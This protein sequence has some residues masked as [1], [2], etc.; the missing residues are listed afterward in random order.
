MRS[1]ALAPLAAA[2]L[3]VFPAAGA[4][5]DAAPADPSTADAGTSSLQRVEVTGTRQRLDAARNAL[6]PDTGSSV[7]RLDKQDLKNLPLGESTPLNQVLLQT[8]GVVQD[9]YGQLHVRGDHA[10]VQYR[11]NGVII[12]ES[13]SGFGQALET[14]FADH[15][16]V[17]TGALPAQYGIRNAAVVDIQSKGDTPDRGGSVGLTLGSRGH[18]ETSLELSGTQGQLNYF[19]T[20]SLLRNDV[21]IENP[22]G[23][24]NALH[25]TT[26]QAK[27][28]GLLSY[29]LGDDSRVSLMFGTSNNRF[30]IPN[31]AGQSPR[32]TTDGHAPLDS[33]ALDARQ[34][35]SNRFVV[36]SYQGAIGSRVDYQLS[37][38]NRM[39]D[40]HYRPDAIGDL[41][42]NGI[43]ADILRRNDASGLQADFSY[44]LNPAHTLRAGLFA[45]QEKVD[46]A[47]GASVFPADADGNQSSGVP[48]FIQDD[49]RISG[50]LW[51]AYLQD[52]W[53]PV[54]PLTINYGLRYDQVHTVVVERQFS[55]RLGLVY[56]ASETLRLHAGYARYFTPPPTEKID[57]TSVAKFIGTTNALPSDANTAVRSERSDYF[58]AGLS[59]QASPQL[60][61]GID[62]YYRKVRHLQDEGQF[63]NAL[64]FSAFNFEQGR[65][66]GLDLSATY[67]GER[68]SGYVNLGL[69]HARAKGIESGQFNFGPD[70][71]D[72]IASHWVHLDHEQRFSGSAGLSYRFGGGLVASSDLLFGSGLRRGFANTGHLPAYTSVNAAVAKTFDLGQG[73]GKFDTRLAVVNLFDRVYQLRDGSGIGVGAPQFGLRRSVYVSVGKPF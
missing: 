66:H 64:I 61:L 45:Q 10:N 26:R 42:F 31:L 67:K 28:F 73:L 71:L 9:S 63:G 58:D 44:K 37:V 8:P 53:R 25:D 40:V 19:L 34:N 62:G 27:S 55:P 50:H 3:C 49:S 24:R 5:A 22:T 15:L 70:E 51:S 59:F 13:I 18:V 30:Q 2:C 46:V 23:A 52:E 54:K 41:Q 6:S 11:I 16:N 65:I 4:R 38:F 7:Y 47:N 72:Y 48:V 43:A 1:F 56:E 36:A 60:T 21:G 35:E 12:P 17:L 57:T 68:L 20:G 14:R 32:F 33:A 69:S 29:V 39:T